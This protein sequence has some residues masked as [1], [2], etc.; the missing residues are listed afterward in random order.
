MK[1]TA[2]A[3]TDPGVL[4]DH[5][6][7]HFVAR[8]DLGLYMVADGVGGHKAG[9]I[10]SNVA[11]RLIED[12]VRS[13]TAALPDNTQHDKLLADAIRQA[14]DALVEYGER[15]ANRRGL[16][17][18][19]TVLWFH[20]DR[21]L[22]AYVGDSRIYLYRNGVLRQLSRDEKAGRYKLAACLGHDAAIDPHLGMVRLRAGDR[23]LLCSDGLHGPVD[24]DDLLDAVDA[25]ADPARCAERLVA[26]ANDAGGPDNVT[27]LV[28]DVLE[29]DRRTPWRFS[30]ARYDATSLLT[31]LRDKRRWLL[32]AAVAVLAIAL[33]ILA[34]SLARRPDAHDE[35]PTAGALAVYLQHVNDPAAA[36]DHQATL[37]A[38]KALIHRAV[39]DRL[40]LEHGSIELHP[41]AEALYD[42]AARDVWNE[43]LA[44][45][46]K[47][48]AQFAGT[49]VEAYA[50]A[51]QREPRQRIEKLRR[52]FLDHRDYR[53]VLPTLEELAAR[54]A[55]IAAQA[56][57]RL[58]DRIAAAKTK[59]AELRALAADRVEPQRKAIELRIRA[60]NE[61]L[62][63]G[64]LSQA[65]RILKATL[66]TL[67]S[68][69][70]FPRSSNP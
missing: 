61:A 52:Q 49:A 66:D 39:Q 68:G 67:D 25:E 48:L 46:R 13:G 12:A 26:A 45:V 34:A 30:F 64:N 7:D 2:A 65:E 58:T 17:T 40:H 6:E 50:Q 54:T 31:R 59:L 23:F 4:T 62:N 38:L 18:T 15:E 47:N 69:K 36:G 3:R 28:A 21:V 16:G 35:A 63:A 56:R 11:C 37:E 60:A 43:L 8:R 70:P 41:D 29:P 14:N 42:Q 57:R 9:E 33:L 44:P 24:P 27:A 53:T 5:N 19:I 22:F 10:A 20:G 51:K 55:H 1:L 32:V